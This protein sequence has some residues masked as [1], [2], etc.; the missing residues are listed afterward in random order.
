MNDLHKKLKEI[1]ASMQSMLDLATAESR[2]FTE[3]EEKQY[4]EYEASTD[5][6]QKQIERA[7]KL[8]KIQESASKSVTESVAQKQ[9]IIHAPADP[10]KTEFESINEFLHAAIIKGDDQRLEYVAQTGNMNQGSR[11]GFMIPK[12]F[13]SE[14]FEQ[15]QRAVPIYTRATRLQSD[16]GFPD[17][18]VEFPALVQENGVLGGVEAHFIAEGGTKPQTGFEL[19]TVTWKP[20]EAAATFKVTDKLLRNWQGMPT[21][22]SGKL[23]QALLALYEKRF[24]RGNGVG[25]PLGLLNLPALIKINRATSNRITYQDLI[26]MELRS[27]INEGGNYIWLV[28]ERVR[29]ELRQIKNPVGSPAEGDGALILVESAREDN[30]SVMLGKPVVYTEFGSALGALGDVLLVNLSD[31]QILD[32]LSPIVASDGGLSGTNFDNNMTT[33]KIYATVDG[34]SQL[35]APYKLE[36]TDSHTFSSFIGLDVPQG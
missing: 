19:R 10:A 28:S 20:Q 4:A 12:R 6:L 5:S 15:N 24:M 36:P 29:G 25:C 16:A 8:Q 21:Y 22:V 23:N 31:Y 3:D 27:R 32:G 17:Q 11:G 34:R 1:T 13:V 9:D 30:A 35:N 7:N 33:I 2:D 26:N 14:I 18:E